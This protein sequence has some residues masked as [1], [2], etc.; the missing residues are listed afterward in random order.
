[1]TTI[2]KLRP[3]VLAALAVALLAPVAPAG[4]G[5]IQRST[6]LWPD[7][8]VRYS[9]GPGVTAASTDPRRH[10]A[11]SSS[12]PEPVPRRRPEASSS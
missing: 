5:V 4:A 12:R 1:M 6:G 9:F 8:Q 10:E 11:P 7:G 2:G 3:T